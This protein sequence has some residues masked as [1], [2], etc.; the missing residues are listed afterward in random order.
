[1]KRLIIATVTSALAA[2]FMFSLAACSAKDTYPDY[3]QSAYDSPIGAAMANA[4][5]YGDKIPAGEEEGS[6]QDVQSVMEYYGYQEKTAEELSFL[7]GGVTSYD[8]CTYY[9]KERSYT[10]DGKEVLSPAVYV[11]PSAASSLKQTGNKYFDDADT[12]Y[13]WICYEYFCYQYLPEGSGYSLLTVSNMAT[14]E[15]V[16]VSLG[17]SEGK[18]H[19]EVSYLFSYQLGAYFDDAV[20]A[21]YNGTDIS[22]NLCKSTFTL[23]DGS[24]KI[25]DITLKV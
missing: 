18:P 12:S 1:M 4:V 16:K 20:T 19:N 24:T 15:V 14:C 25:A 11:C 17:V 21:S 8:S 6:F 5:W 13:V 3:P 9:Y 22:S 23:T 7:S 2:T 10:V